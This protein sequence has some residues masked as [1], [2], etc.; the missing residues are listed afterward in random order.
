VYTT[1]IANET[2]AVKATKKSKLDIDD[3]IQYTAALS[4]NADAIISLAKDFDGLK[5]LTKEPIQII[6]DMQN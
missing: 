6:T 1:S 4:I 2:K 3:A 5:I